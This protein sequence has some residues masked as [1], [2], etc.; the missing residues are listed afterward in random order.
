MRAL[1][2]HVLVVGDNKGRDFAL[3]QAVKRSRN[4]ARVDVVPATESC[5]QLE[6]LA[7]EASIQG[8]G[9]CVVGPERP[10]VAGIGD[11]FRKN[12][13]PIMCPSK[14]AA[15]LEGSKA[16]TK[17]ICVRYGIPTAEYRTARDMGRAYEVIHRLGMPL[18]LKEDGLCD[19]K[20]VHIP[21][22][23]ADAVRLAQEILE[24]A[25]GLSPIVIERKL[26]GYELSFT[27]LCDGVNVLPLEYAV[28][29]K[30]YPGTDDMTGGMGAYSHPRIVSRRLRRQ[31]LSMAKKL[32]RAMQKEGTPYHGVLYLGIMVTKK[33]PMLLEVN[34]RFGDPE[35]QVLLERLKSDLVPYLL[36]C[37]TYGGLAHMPRLQWRKEA[38][39]CVSLVEPGYPKSGHRVGSVTRLGKTLAEAHARTYRAVRRYP[40]IEKLLYHPNIAAGL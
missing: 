17:L 33:G 27:A 12:G 14:E 38:A 8:V 9:L 18:V 2:L 31:I 10:V 30:R 28:D 15:E 16:R 1:K 36:A 40:G 4:V 39:V 23:L 35:A 26:D 34:C 3:C 19:G 5:S 37:D 20:G 21:K 29:E 24:K 25:L 7:T 13:I 11:I 22:S 6:A 32:V